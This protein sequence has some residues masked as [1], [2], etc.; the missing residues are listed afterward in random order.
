MTYHGGDGNAQGRGLFVGDV[1]WGLGARAS[2]HNDVLSKG[3]VVVVHA[4]SVD[5]RR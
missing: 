3:A 5:A 2:L 1:V 4:V